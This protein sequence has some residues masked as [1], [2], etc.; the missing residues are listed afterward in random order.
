MK[1]ICLL[2]INVYAPAEGYKSN[3]IFFERLT[4]KIIKISDREQ[5][6]NTNVFIMMGGDMNAICKTR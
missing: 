2:F 3:S 4:K 1:K 6:E 5:Q